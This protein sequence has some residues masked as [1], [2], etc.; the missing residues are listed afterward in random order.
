MEDK[1]PENREIIIQDYWWEEELSGM[2]REYN[3]GMIEK[4]SIILFMTK[5]INAEKGYNWQN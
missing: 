1:E 3:Q 5:V 2:L 4:E